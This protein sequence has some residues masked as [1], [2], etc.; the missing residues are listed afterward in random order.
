MN[1]IACYWNWLRLNDFTSLNAFGAH[2]LAYGASTRY[3][4]DL[5]QIG[6]KPAAG[7]PRGMQTNSTL[8]LGQTMPDNPIAGYRTLSANITSSGHVVLLQQL[9]KGRHYTG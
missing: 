4:A 6:K 7:N 8:F 9:S 2:R 1:Y 3:N 5:L